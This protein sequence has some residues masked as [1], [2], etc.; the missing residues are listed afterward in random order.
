[1]LTENIV[2]VD[3]SS[4]QDFNLMYLLFKAAS[5]ELTK[6]RII[7]MGDDNQLKPVGVGA[8]FLDLINSKLI[9][10][11]KLTKIYRQKE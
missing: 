2:L 9:P 1:M 3:E 5:F 6:K 11:T 8:P 10:L 4:M 7:I